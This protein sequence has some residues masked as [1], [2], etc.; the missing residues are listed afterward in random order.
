MT[1]KHRRSVRS[2]LSLAAVS[3]LLWPQSGIGQTREEAVVMAHEGHTEEAIAA[4]RKLLSAST[5]DPAVAFDLAVIL[6]W[7]H[8]PKEA[9]DAFER[10]GVAEPPDYV[11][12]PIIRAYRDQKRFPEAERW[13]R[14][15]ARRQPMDATPAKL[16]GLILADEGRTKEA[17]AV[18]EPWSAVQ[19]DDPEVWLAMGYAAQRAGDRFALLRNY[20]R[21]LR[22]QPANGEAR[23]V[24]ARTLSD[25]GAPHGAAAL[26]TEV[27]LSVRASELG[28]QVRWGEK[29]TPR[30]P[31][32]R[33]DEI[34]A[35]L[36]RLERL[37]AHARSERPPDRAL[38]LR[39]RS[40]RVKA[41]RVRERWNDTLAAAAQ[42]RA[43]GVAL[44]PYVR[45]AEADALLALRR[46]AEARQ[47]YE[48]VLRGEPKNRDA[49]IGRF[50]CLVEEENFR[51]AFREADAL[52]ASDSAGMRQP[53]QRTTQPNG[54]WLEGQ[55]LA[56]RAR[57]YAGMPVEAWHLLRPLVEGAPA[58]AELRSAE[59]SFAASND[60]PRQGD[61]AIHIAA[62]LSP[63]DKGVQIALMETAIRRRRWAEARQ[64]ILALQAL[65]PTDSAVLRA[66]QDL[67]AHDAFELRADFLYR[68][69]SSSG[70]A[71]LDN[72]PGPGTEVR[73]R[74]YT[75]PVADVL[76]FF[77]AWDHFEAKVAEGIAQR[78][79]EGAGV[80]LALPD[81]T[82][83]VTGWNNDGALSR[84][85]GDMDLTWQPGD[86][87]TFTVQA[88]LFTGETP[89]RAVLNGIYANSVGGSVQYTWDASRSLRLSGEWYRFSDGNRRQ[90]AG[91]VFNQRI[92]NLPHLDVWLRPEVYASENS[93]DE[94][95]YFSPLRDFSAA[96]TVDVEQVLWR[97]YERSFRHRLAISGGS[98]GQ[99]NFGIGWTGNLLYEQVYRC[100]PWWEFCYGVQ[101][102]RAVYDAVGTPSLEG[103][104]K[105]N[106]RF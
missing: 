19:P 10:A 29:I 70:E 62:S 50:Y 2:A 5:P 85:G 32:H 56:A 60:W 51:E 88:A 90:S 31:R 21:A 24:M 36:V 28:L 34:D 48:A 39:M 99:K 8:R 40:D 41:L 98:Y 14:E 59:G 55:L 72:A 86:H 93:S 100:D 96:L 7:V 13:A 94:G 18:L 58:N 78:Y 95:P 68:Y 30:D 101:F 1:L 57:S 23:Q 76:R 69:E 42:L 33:F 26:L 61:E 75:P 46:P 9:T 16:L 49:H 27:P 44:P 43:E 92:V 47:G 82:A 87:W 38:I 53:N 77:G 54:D 17:L 45:E 73:T 63:E 25:L 81:I 74:L 65:Y 97:H 105:W 12:G 64:R 11:L 103:I 35:A 104:V 84:P 79:R 71:K 83:E 106:L 37:L 102:N 15:A 3:I 4:L 20:G 89:L 22:L 80:E 91:L 66:Q 52:A 67:R 6:T